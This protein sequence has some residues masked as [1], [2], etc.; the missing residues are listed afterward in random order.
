MKEMILYGPVVGGNVL[1]VRFSLIRGSRRAALFLNEV[2]RHFDEDAGTLLAAGLAFNGLLTL[3]PSLLLLT[4]AAAIVLSSDVDVYQRLIDYIHVVLPGIDDQV[5]KVIFDLVRNKEVIGIVG[6]LGLSWTSARIFGSVR[7]VLQKVLRTPRG[8]A[9]LH[10]KLFDFGMAFASGVLLALSMV[11]TTVLE[12]LQSYGAEHVRGSSG[13]AVHLPQWGA[14]LMSVF[15]FYI[16]LRYVPV[17]RVRQGSALLGSVVTA[18][19]WE[20][21]KWGLTAYLKRVNDMSAIYGSLGLVVVLALWAY[22][23]AMAFVIGAEFAAVREEH[24]ARALARGEE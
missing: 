24:L 6:I 13:L 3:V 8:R 9:Y 1:N 5:L 23:S 16:I 17:D 21:T 18:I 22:Y 15:T 7:T 14:F 19:M 2:R 11:L 20:V 4:S 10:G 12:A